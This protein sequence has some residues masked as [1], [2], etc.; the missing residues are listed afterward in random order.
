VDCL[1][2]E[3]PRSLSI[4]KSEPQSAGLARLIAKMIEIEQSA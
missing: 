1:V 3:L 4:D 2:L